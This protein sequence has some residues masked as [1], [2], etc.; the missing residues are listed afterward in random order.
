MDYN[1]RFTFNIY[2]S[3]GD[4]DNRNDRNGSNSSFV[5]GLEKGVRNIFA[6]FTAVDICMAIKHY[7]RRQSDEYFYDRSYNVSFCIFIYIIMH[8]GI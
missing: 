8:G 6:V 7:D 1:I 3:A 4:F 5:R 2:I